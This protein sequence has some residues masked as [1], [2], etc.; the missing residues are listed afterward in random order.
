MPMVAETITAVVV[1]AG[2]I[3]LS[4]DKWHARN[5]VQ[6]V[7]KQIDALTARNTL[8]HKENRAILDGIGREVHDVTLGIK[9][10]DTKIERHMAWH[11]GQKER[12]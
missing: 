3:L 2:A 12:N 7:K 1:A 6:D 11:E 9:D 4:W 10:V 8:E 5:G